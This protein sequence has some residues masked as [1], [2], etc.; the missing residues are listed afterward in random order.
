M[1]WLGGYSKWAYLA[2]FEMQFSLPSQRGPQL[3]PHIADHQFLFLS[4]WKSLQITFFNALAIGSPSGLSNSSVSTQSMGNNLGLI[5]KLCSF[6][7]KIEYS[8][9]HQ[10]LFSHAGETRITKR[11]DSF[12]SFLSTSG[13]TSPISMSSL[14]WNTL[15]SGM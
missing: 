14:S 2:S 7:V 12:N 6:F 8:H 10:L 15:M 4:F 13:K 1:Q 11:S 9:L 3:R 5:P